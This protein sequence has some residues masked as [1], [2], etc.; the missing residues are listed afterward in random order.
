M[1][2]GFK[3]FLVGITAVAVISD[4][5]LIPFYPQ[6]FMA[7]FGITDAQYV[8]MYLAVYGFVVMLAFP[9]WAAVAKHVPT[10]QLLVYTQF[11]AGVLSILCYWAAT[12]PIFWILSLSM[13]LFK[14]SYLLIY[15]YLLS[16]VSKHQHGG[17]IGLLSVVVNFGAIL[18]AI[19]GGVILQWFEPRQAFVVMAVGDFIQMAVCFGLIKWRME[20]ESPQP[21]CVDKPLLP[22]QQQARISA[23]MNTST[24]LKLSFVMLVFYFS[25]YLTYHFF[26]RYWESVSLYDD[27]VVSSLVFA[28]PA[29]MA[30][31][32]LWFNHH[33]GKQLKVSAGIIT[34]LLLGV[35]GL[36]LQSTQEEVWVLLGRCLF[37]WALFQAIVRLDLL[38]FHLSTPETYVT[39]YSKIRIFQSLGVLLAAY[40]AG[41]I[42]A[43]FSGQMMFIAASFG[44]SFTVVS[45]IYLFKTE[46]KASKE[47]TQLT[48]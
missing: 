15:P 41:F 4:S 34:A 6:F 26:I 47:V 3:W 31:L 39:D 5:M 14:A 28:I 42:V 27:E 40:V 2:P 43:N 10:L 44:L 8:G 30:L 19:L 37:G 1:S 35:G 7:V 11:A 17:T 13:M 9:V 16:Q 21:Y 20:P 12:A 36:L 25:A 18:G 33:S 24:V 23:R 48:T 46:M 32:G 22:G 38:L 45:F 29:F